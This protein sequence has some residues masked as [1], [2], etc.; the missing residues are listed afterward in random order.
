MAI[1][2][3]QSLVQYSVDTDTGDIKVLKK[4]TTPI[5]GTQD[6]KAKKIV[7]TAMTSTKLDDEYL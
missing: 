5:K 3:F 7:K 4:F 2:T 6:F 1:L